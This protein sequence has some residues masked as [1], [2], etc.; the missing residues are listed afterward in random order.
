MSYLDFYRE[1]A[2]KYVATAKALIAAKAAV[3]AAEN[4]VE[5]SVAQ[6]KLVDTYNVW[7][8]LT[9]GAKIVAAANGELAAA[10]TAAQALIPNP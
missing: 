2:D 10:I 7:V 1:V 4:P 5:Q 8:N 3:D 6:K 9:K